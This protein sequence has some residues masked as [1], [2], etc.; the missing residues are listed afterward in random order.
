MISKISCFAVTTLSA[1][2]GGCATS[3]PPAPAPAPKSPGTQVQ[4]NFNFTPD[5]QPSSPKRVVRGAI[6]G[7]PQH[8][9][10]YYSVN[11]DCSSGG[12]VQTHLKNAPTH[13]S[14]AFDK[15]DDYTSFPSTSPGHECNSKKSPGVEVLYTSTKDFVGAD[16]FT[17]VGIGPKG[18]YMETDY[19]VNVVAP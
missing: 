8:V 14:V 19:T 11:P 1:I 10:F 4:V 17:V 12:L 2:I 18:K 15:T 5:G 7:V 6:S 3:P 13:G 16:Q 9:G